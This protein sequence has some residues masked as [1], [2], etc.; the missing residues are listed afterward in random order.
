MDVARGGKEN[1][2]RS[3]QFWVDSFRGPIQI[4]LYGF[5][6]KERDSG[7]EY[8]KITPRISDCYLA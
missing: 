8:L 2:T 3:L 1:G 7:Q 6:G 4:Y 5:I